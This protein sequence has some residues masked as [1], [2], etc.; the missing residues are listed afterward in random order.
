M[1]R[2]YSAADLIEAHL[3][4]HQLRQSGIP[5]RIFNENAQGAVG[6]L[7]VDHACPEVWLERDG[8]EPKARRVIEEYERRPLRRG[9]RH[10]LECGER[11]PVNFELCWRCGAALD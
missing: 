10:C 8:D 5:A 2:V 4:L 6:E 11:S 7:P 1:I 9:I 3:V